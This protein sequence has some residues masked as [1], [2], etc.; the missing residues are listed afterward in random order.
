MLLGIIRDAQRGVLGGGV[1]P[2]ENF[3]PKKSQRENLTP[4]Q[5]LE[6]FS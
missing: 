4:P 3:V 5:I 1:A 6:I 2:L